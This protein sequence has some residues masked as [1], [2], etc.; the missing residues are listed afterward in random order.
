VATGPVAR[1]SSAPAW[2]VL[3][4]VLLRRAALVARVAFDHRPDP[5]AGL[6]IDDE[7]LEKLLTELPGLAVA[8]HSVI[9]AIERE[10]RPAV[11]QAR[12]E[13]HRLIEQTSSDQISGNDTFSRIVRFARLSELETEVLALACAVELDPRR[14]RVVGYLN[15]DVSQRRLSLFT[16]QL[17]FPEQPD[18]GLAIS[19]G[20]GLRRA[21]LLAPAEPGV[22]G[23]VALA[24]SPTVFWWLAGDRARDPDLPAGTDHIAPA[25]SQPPSGPAKP[26]SASSG[27][28][29]ASPAKPGP[30]R[31][32]TPTALPGTDSFEFGRLVLVPGGDKLR[33]RQ[34]ASASL[35]P[36][37]ASPLPASPPAWDALVRQATLE[38]GG[39]LIELDGPLPAEA[40]QRIEQADH[41][42][43]A[44]ASVDELPLDCLPA[45]A[46]RELA[47]APAP[48]NDSEWAEAVASLA[49]SGT[50][51]EDLA[52]KTAPGTPSG[53]GAS[54]GRPVLGNYGL[55]AEQLELVRLAAPGVGGISAAVR[56][57]AAGH[58]STLAPR[59]RPS[60]NWDDLVLDRDRTERLREVVAR[61][62]H[63][64]KVYGTWGFSALPSGGVVGLFSGP[65]GTGKTLAAEII[66]GELGLDLYK[67][68]L[69]ALVSKW[70]GETEKNLSQV[71]AAAEASN[72]ALFF[73]EADAIFGRRSEVSDSHDRY[74]NIEVA[75]LL[76]RLERY[77]GLVLMATNLATNIDPAFLRR[78][79]VHVDFPMPEEP[80]RRRIWERSLP[81]GAPRD[82][83]DLDVLAKL[84]KLSGGSIRNATLTAGFLAADAGTVIDMAAIVEAVQREMRK[85]GRLLTAADFGPYANL[86][87]AGGAEVPARTSAAGK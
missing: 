10:A 55:S 44:L 32:E 76:Q 84:F 81:P 6:K 61:C 9:G 58:I 87:N 57:L 77:E 14:Q 41:L 27:P 2:T 28:A 40:R 49:A 83:L 30:A 1:Q 59:T 38:Q 73:D 48:A 85:L 50:L 70:V 79:H 69:A 75:Y 23:S 45:V 16:L 67:V 54:W 25:A 21:A 3:A 78:I 37:L 7:D 56:R 18:V 19:P 52:P 65:S 80:E 31:R 13:L 39:V 51:G 29:K 12:A 26:G 71:F 60:R 36:L 33:R 42:S 34:A 11:E 24:P 64:K 68:D 74:A 53:D 46:W 43:W 82:N 47:V 66:S 62:R 15:D 72:V 17:L 4:D 63:K 35:G 5:L 86:L 8:D 20:G 22:L